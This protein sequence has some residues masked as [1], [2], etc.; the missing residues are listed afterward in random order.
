M[1]TVLPTHK[2]VKVT[3]KTPEPEAGKIWTDSY[4]IKYLGDNVEVS[5]SVSIKLSKN[6]QSAGLEGGVKFKTTPEL[7]DSAIPAASEKIRA[8]LRS[9]LKGLREEMENMP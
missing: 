2:T 5:V 3:P 8:L 6:Y 4:G 1:I 7:V 9:Q